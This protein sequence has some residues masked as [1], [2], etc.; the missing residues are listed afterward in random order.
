MGIYSL[1]KS[2]S[3]ERYGRSVESRKRNWRES[4]QSKHT[5]AMEYKMWSRI[6]GSRKTNFESRLETGFRKINIVEIL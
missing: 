5:P 4:E 6:M 2:Y 1:Q 3:R